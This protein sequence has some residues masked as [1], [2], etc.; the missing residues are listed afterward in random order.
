[1]RPALERAAPAAAGRTVRQGI[2]GCCAAIVMITGGAARGLAADPPCPALPSIAQ[3]VA[4]DER[5]REE[6]GFEEERHLR[7]FSLFWYRNL[8]NDLVDGRG[9]AYD[10]LADAFGPACADRNVLLAWLRE[11]LLASQTG[12]D[13]SRRLAMA[14]A[15]AVPRGRRGAFES[16]RSPP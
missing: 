14:R 6:R 8:A 4:D 5:L 16:H 12:A 15:G 1:M 11:L 9:P 10:V 13:F 3:V 2:A 7:D